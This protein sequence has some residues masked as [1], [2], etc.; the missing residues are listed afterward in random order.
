MGV[1]W[2]LAVAALTMAAL[3]A[4]VAAPTGADAAP[5]CS[6]GDSDNLDYQPWAVKRIA[7]DR[8]WPISQGSGVTVAVLD[9]GVNAQHRQL[10][11]RVEAGTDLVRGK[12]TADTDCAGHGSMVAGIIAGKR[13]DGS[14][15]YG[16]APEATIL[17]IRIAE[18]LGTFEHGS[19]RIAAAIRY[20]VDHDAT[21]INMSLTTEDSPQLRSAVGYAHEHGVVMVA[22][23]GNQADDKPRYPAAYPDV[24]AVGGIDSSGG[25]DSESVTGDWVDLAAP[26]TG[27]V[28]PAGIGSGYLSEKGTSFA[29]PVV[30][31]TAALIRAYRPELTPD[32]VATRLEATAD[33]PVDGH[34]DEVGYGVVNPYRAL[35]EVLG[36]PNGAATAA[37]GA[38]PAAASRTGAADPV[39]T[40]ALWAAVGLL[41]VVIALLLLAVVVPAGRRRGWRPGLRGRLPGP[42]STRRRPPDYDPTAPPPIEP[43]PPA[44]TAVRL[45][46][47]DSSA[48][49]TVDVHLN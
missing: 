45:P 22:A 44:T 26:S 14:G 16:V 9:S 34:N 28:A 21:V 35:T 27:I 40:A 8:A 37:G 36:E 20:A 15:F 39:R 5:Q 46:G 38:L 42:R 3:G 19:P 17:P 12:G 6:H 18:D 29:A 31:G 49:F 13:V 30:A 32:Q 4:P 25:H 1:P 2:R 48:T 23:T 10:A 7:A 43:E 47:S 11:G 33:H 24:I 41:A